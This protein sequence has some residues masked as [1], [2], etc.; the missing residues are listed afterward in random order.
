MFA[1]SFSK[2]LLLALVIGVVWYGWKYAKKV[3]AVRRNLNEELQREA[4]T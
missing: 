2:L 4:V 3:E 1:L